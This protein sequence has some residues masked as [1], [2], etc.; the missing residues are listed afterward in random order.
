MGFPCRRA[1]SHS[2]QQSTG[3]TVSPTFPKVGS[4]CGTKY[5]M[6][7]WLPVPPILESHD[8]ELQMYLEALWLGAIKLLRSLWAM[9]FY[10]VFLKKKENKKFEFSLYHIHI[11]GREY[12]GSQV[13]T[14]VLLKP[15][16]GSTGIRCP[17]SPGDLCTFH[18]GHS[19]LGFW[20]YWKVGS[21]SFICLVTVKM[22]L[23]LWRNHSGKIIK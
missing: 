3:G 19:V 9:W 5:I 2:R 12:C 13:K 8:H 7:L 17:L 15:G 1:E 23:S 10:L 14:W 16:T 6:N 21:H 4:R 11:L 18:Q 22:N 20:A